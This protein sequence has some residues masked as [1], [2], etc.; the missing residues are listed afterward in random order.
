MHLRYGPCNARRAQQNTFS[1]SAGEP[2]LL[3][4]DSA[5][6][7]REEH[8]LPLMVV[9]GAAAGDAGRT[10]FNDTFA[11]VRLSGFQYG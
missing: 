9:A 8:L 5:A 4:L 3:S 7:L 11:G 10:A 6:H 2:K 1:K